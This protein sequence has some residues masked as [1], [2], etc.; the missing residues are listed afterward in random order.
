MHT[1]SNGDLT[2]SCRANNNDM[3]LYTERYRDRQTECE[4]LHVLLCRASQLTNNASLLITQLDTP[5][6]SRDIRAATLLSTTKLKIRERFYTQK[7]GS[8][9]YNSTSS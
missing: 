2:I 9:L 7:V 8:K 3:R 1:R 5:A 4:Q 6:F